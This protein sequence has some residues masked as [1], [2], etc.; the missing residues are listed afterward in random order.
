ML[1]C[2]NT[3]NKGYPFYVLPYI[4]DIHIFLEERMILFD[5]VETR[6]VINSNEFPFGAS[7]PLQTLL[8]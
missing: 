6:N 4:S 2:I 5:L 3:K 7:Q 1:L 8:L